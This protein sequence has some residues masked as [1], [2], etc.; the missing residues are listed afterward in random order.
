MDVVIQSFST[1]L[2]AVLTPILLVCCHPAL[3]LAETLDLTNI[4]HLAYQ[5]S[6]R[7]RVATSA[8]NASLEAPKIAR[9]ALLPQ[10][11][12]FGQYEDSNIDSTG[13]YPITLDEDE[14][15][16]TPEVR[17]LRPVNSSTETSQ[18]SWGA[19]LSQTVFDASKWF[20]FKQ[21]Q[22]VS[23]E[24][25][26]RFSLEQ[27]QFIYDICER[28][29]NT[30]RAL[31][32]LAISTQIENARMAQVILT[33]RRA[34]NGDSNTID[35]YRAEAALDESRAQRLIDEDHLGAA[36][37]D[38]SMLAGI[39]ISHIAP[40][41]DSFTVTIPNT[42]DRE[43]WLQQALT[44]NFEIRLAEISASIELTELKKNRSKRLP[45]IEITLTYN[46][47]TKNTHEFDN[48]RAFDFD[49]V[50]S[51]PTLELTAN[52]PLFT[53]GTVTAERQQAY[54]KYRGAVARLEASRADVK[55]QLYST[56]RKSQHSEN[57][58]E[59]TESAVVSARRAHLAVTQGYNAGISDTIALLES[60]Q[61]YQTAMRSFT[62]A[63]YDQ[64]LNILNLQRITAL[65]SPEVIDELNAYLGIENE[66]PR[67]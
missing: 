55:R 12:V 51:G 14:N 61:R 60:Q 44:N 63:R 8:M 38:L 1:R 67:L 9:G 7:L 47:N 31:D 25:L 16:S 23:D 64:I 56:L 10:F 30:L 35:V 2:Y 34:N 32:D 54:F 6:A 59:S 13:L 48:N 39:D 21:A 58:L 4:Y 57:I 5:N 17:A 41:A 43:H 66:T 3:S 36:F 52:W 65:L 15:P 22:F 19:R 53:S 50:S 29:F 42:E 37:D 33:K 28:Y 20:N 24:A 40:M 27:S 26:V 18:H 45:T 46:D 49:S 11:T 62:H